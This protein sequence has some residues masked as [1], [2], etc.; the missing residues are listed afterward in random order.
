VFRYFPSTPN[1]PEQKL[2][3]TLISINK[4]SMVACTSGPS[5]VGGHK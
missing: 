3:K 1:L 4:L 2:I 5:Y